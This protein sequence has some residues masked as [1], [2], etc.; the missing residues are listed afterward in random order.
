MSKVLTLDNAI[1]NKLYKIVSCNPQQTHTHT[2]SPNHKHVEED[3]KI[4]KHRHM[5]THANDE[6]KSRFA[7][8]GLVTGTTVKVLKSA[9]LGDPIEIEFRSYKLCI[10]KS[11]AK[12]FLV[13]AVSAEGN[14]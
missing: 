8:M 7:E 4:S 5:H 2:H 13:E 14:Q 11:E 3:T 12:M 1:H 6:L 9:P 10:R